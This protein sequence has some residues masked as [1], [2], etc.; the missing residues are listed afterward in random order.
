MNCV[1]TVLPIFVA[2]FFAAS[3]VNA[4][5]S[6]EKERLLIARQTE[7]HAKKNREECSKM[8]FP[9][10]AQDNRCFGIYPSEI[11]TWGKGFSEGLAK[12]TVNGKAGFIDTNGK[13][14]IRPKFNDAGRF[15]EGLAPFESS[16]GKWGYIDRTGKVAI[17]PIFDWAISFNEGL[18]LVQVGELWGFIDST[19]KAVIPAKF[20]EAESFSDGV[21]AV[22]YYDKDIEWMAATPRK[23]R[24]VYQ[25]IDKT[26]A[27]AFPQSFDG[28]HRGFDG[29]LAIVSRSLGYSEKYKG[30]ISETYVI[31]ASGRELWKLDSASTY[32]FTEDAIVVEVKRTEKVYD[33]L[34][35]FK[36]R[37]GKLLCP[38]NYENPSSFSEGLAVV[39]VEGKYG[40]L[41]KKCEFAIQPTFLEAESFSEG[42]AWVKDESGFE[43]FIDRSGAVA[44]KTDHQW[45]GAF[46]DGFALVLD[47]QKAG[48]INKSG[49][50]VWQPTH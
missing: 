48:Y 22:G 27:A 18:G 43:G 14:V 6:G 25:F 11:T 24:W 50:L 13:L 30:T 35:N 5:G 23:G 37:S 1:R 49:K 2:V 20:E 17:H 42:L 40:Y 8:G 36:D 38:T 21:A 46:S 33:S 31:D 34:Y 29:G 7:K 44:F 4:Q 15:S 28:I 47:G 16:N 9:A 19:G 39:R 12:V 32:W 3:L 41:N 10:S 45:V 26:G